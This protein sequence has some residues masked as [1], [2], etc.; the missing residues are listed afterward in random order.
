MCNVNA[1]SVESKRTQSGKLIK[2]WKLC[3]C[4]VLIHTNLS[5]PLC[6]SVDVG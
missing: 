6:M 5:V 2:C 3:A 4:R 1:D